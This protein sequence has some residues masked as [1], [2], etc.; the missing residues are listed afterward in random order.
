MTAADSRFA[1]ANARKPPAVFAIWIFLQ[2]KIFLDGRR[3]EH[4]GDVVLLGGS[5]YHVGMR[6]RPD[7]GIELGAVDLEDRGKLLVLSLFVRQRRIR[8]RCE[9]D[10]DVEPAHVAGMPGGHRTTTWHAQVA[11]EKPVVAFV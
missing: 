9:P 8:H 5:T 4:T 1:R 2:A 7:S 11:D 3:G 10:V 6:I